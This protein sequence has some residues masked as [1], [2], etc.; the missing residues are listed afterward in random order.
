MLDT[1]NTFFKAASGLMMRPSDN[2][3]FLMYSQTF[4]VTS[5]RGS[6]DLPQI[7]ASSV[8][9][10]FGAKMPLPAFFLPLALLAALP[11]AFF[12]AL[13][14]AFVAF[15]IVGFFVFVVATVV[16]VV[17]AVFVVV[18]IAIEEVQT[19]LSLE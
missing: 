12:V 17:T 7:A 13:S 6:V 19:R 8:L 4:L 11:A 5:V 1:G 16:F 10:F 18:V 2:L 14:V 3:F 15:V 9:S